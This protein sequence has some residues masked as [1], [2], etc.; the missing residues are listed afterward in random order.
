MTW[1]SH[2]RILMLC[3]AATAFLGYVFSVSALTRVP[4][5]IPLVEMQTALPRFA[6]IAMAGGD[7]Y[8]AANLAFFR[9]LVVSTEKM[10]AENFRIQG[11]VQR[12]VAWLNPAHEDNYYIA[13]AILPWSNEYAAAQEI[14]AKA[15]AARPF[16]YSPA[17]F[18]GFNAMYF[19]RDVNDGARWLRRASEQTRMEDERLLLQEMAAIWMDRS[20]D[21][22]LAA[23]VVAA[24]A[25]HARPKSFR[26][27]LLKRVARLDALAQLRKDVARYVE[28]YG[29]PPAKLEDLVSAH[30]VTELPNDALGKGFVLDA[31]GNVVFAPIGLEV[32]KKPEP[33]VTDG[34]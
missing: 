5:N 24:M 26:D 9:A 21:P 17:F 28:L 29:A 34:R 10:Q 25:E 8:L 27:Y 7:R 23:S 2:S 33:A 15:A 6:Q 1:V 3:A 32:N 14:L 12:D 22:A 4:R 11:I 13:A 30:L 16:D 31:A 18:Y 20:D 19:K